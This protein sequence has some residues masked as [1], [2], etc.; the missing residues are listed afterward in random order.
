M[1]I[2]MSPENQK[3]VELTVSHGTF[4]DESDAV[5]KALDALREREEL[6]EHLAEAMKSE[7]VPAEVVFARLRHRAEEIASRA[8]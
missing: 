7:S 5:N 4:A 2:E 1:D 6:R 8:E 3:F